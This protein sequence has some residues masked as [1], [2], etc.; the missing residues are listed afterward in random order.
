MYGDSLGALITIIF[1]I[2]NND[3]AIS[4]VILSSPTFG[5]HSSGLA[6]GNTLV[7]KTKRLFM[8]VAP[9]IEDSVVNIG[10]ELSLGAA[11]ITYRHLP[12]ATYHNLLG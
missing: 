3:L 11:V 2:L 4:G 7:D 10:K 1:N 9:Y 12:Q 6:G 5:N 8:E